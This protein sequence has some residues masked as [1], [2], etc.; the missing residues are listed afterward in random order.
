[1]TGLLYAAGVILIILGI[2]VSIAL[3]EIGHLVPAKLFGVKVSQY[4]VGFGPTIFSRKRGDTEY[5]LKALPLGGYIA[6]AGMYPPARDGSVRRSTTGM[7]QTVMDDARKL[8]NEDVAPGEERRTFYSLSVPKKLVVMLGGPVMNLL[9]A[10]VLLGVVFSGFGTLQ[11]TTT[12]SSVSEC[13]VSADEAQ[14]RSAES[15]NK[16]LA[17]DPKAPAALAGIRPGD[18][19]VSVA[20]TGVASWKE[21]Q[22]AIRAQAGKT[23]PVVIE[24]GGE[25]ETLRVAIIASQQAVV[26]DEGRAVVDDSGA[27]KTVEAG[28]LGVSPTN[29]RVQLPLTQL[30]GEIWGTF[31]TIVDAIIHL[32]TRLVDVG[33]AAFSSEERDPE[34]PVGLIGVG[35]VAGEIASTDKLDIVDKSQIGIN[36][37]AT[38]NMFLF[39]FNLV[40]LL[41]L[42]GG[43]VAGA[44]WEGLRRWVAKIFRRR[45]PGPVDTARLLPLTYVVVG[46]MLVMTVL[47][48]Y[49]DIVKPITLF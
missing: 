1:M 38:L 45:D 3:H 4:M 7:F 36:L 37:L 32:P 35:R 15:R 13:V 25:T 48:A 6:M 19:I 12:V 9:I 20:D 14:K 33:K 29:E 30:P 5:G 11:P 2:A 34:G 47:L 16:C 41:P 39:A 44:L 28:F 8:S 21:L 49:A 18:V 22:D 17:A 24:R 43:H 31:T 27:V 26:D 42:D 10:V 23:V 46:V 40:P